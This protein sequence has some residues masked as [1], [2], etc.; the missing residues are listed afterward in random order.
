MAIRRVSVLTRPINIVIISTTLLA[1]LNCA[2][3]PLLSPTVLYADTHSNVILNRL[4]PASKIEMLR[5]AIEITN[6]ER[7]IIAKALLIVVVDISRLYISKRDFPLTTLRILSTAIAK[8]LVLI[9]PPVEP[10]EAPIHIKNIKIKTV[11]MLS[12][13]VS[14]VLKPAVLVVTDPKKAVAILPRKL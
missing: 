12:A 11:G 8:E 1:E 5:I 13:E 14:T 3:M 7:I 2:V 6:I 4:L 9:P 10:G